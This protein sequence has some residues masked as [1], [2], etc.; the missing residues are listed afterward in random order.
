MS[1]LDKI[2]KDLMEAQKKG[3]KIRLSTLRMIKSDL[4]YKQIAKNSPLTEEDELGVLSSA[5][6]KHKDSIEQFKIAQ[7]TD[8]V[9]QEEAELDIISE[10]L[11][12]QLSE[13]E[14]AGLIDQAI[15]ESGAASKTE[16]GKVMKILMPKVKGKADGKLVNSLVT[17]KLS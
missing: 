17:A 11:P 13:E 8:L 12:K 9:E 15:Q 6:K 1:L 2:S 5:V 16:L 3:E 10:Y 14:L 4:K 7:R